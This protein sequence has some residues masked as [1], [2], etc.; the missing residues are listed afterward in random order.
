ML[1]L[2]RLKSILRKIEFSPPDKYLGLGVLFDQAGRIRRWSR[3]YWWN[4]N[5]SNSNFGK[6]K[7]RSNGQGLLFAKKQIW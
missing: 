5:T 3:T 2:G 7:N 4:I 6:G 1:F